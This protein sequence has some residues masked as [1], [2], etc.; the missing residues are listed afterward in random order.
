MER[1]VTFSA[2]RNPGGISERDDR[3]FFVTVTVVTRTLRF[4]FNE[5]RDIKRRGGYTVDLSAKPN[6]PK[7]VTFRN[8]YRRSV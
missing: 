4:A 1:Y 8:D 2:Y 3:L 5:R 6:V 7:T